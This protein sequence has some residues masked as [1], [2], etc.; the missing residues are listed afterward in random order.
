[1]EAVFSF[2]NFR[3]AARLD[4][5]AQAAL[6]RSNPKLE[7]ALANSAAKGLPPISVL[8]LSGQHLSI[9]TQ[10]IGAKSVLEIGTLGGYSTICFAEAGAKVTTIEINPKT[11]R[12]G[13]GE[14]PGSRCRNPP[15]GSARCV[16]EA[17]RGGKAV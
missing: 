16:A 12:R 5:Q 10:L 6:L 1:M 4:A 15:W 13:T 9:L 2:E 7:H 11:S 17:C 14:R 8:P 3:L